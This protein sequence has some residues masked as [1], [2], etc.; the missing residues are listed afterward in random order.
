M[1]YVQKSLNYYVTS[2]I[3]FC[4]KS[5]C[6]L[7]LDPSPEDL[8]CEE[9]VE[10]GR[11]VIEM[12]MATHECFGNDLVFT[13]VFSSF[14]FVILTFYLGGAMLFVAMVRDSFYY[15]AA[16]SSVANIGLGCIYLWRLYQTVASGENIE[17]EVSSK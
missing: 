6:V 4:R 11:Q 9:I 16:W 14:L 3:H 13:E 1:L 5:V 12:I 8:T 2:E 17:N 10:E 7:R 15:F